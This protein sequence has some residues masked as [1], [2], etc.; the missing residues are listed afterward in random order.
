MAN[1]ES[2]Q[3]IVKA[4]QTARRNLSDLEQKLQAEIDEI[5]FDAFREGRDLTPDE[6]ARR[7]QA[8][9][10]QSEV[11]EAFVEIAFVTVSR[12]DHSEEVAALSAR[13][14]RINR[15]LAGDLDR[16]KKIASFASTVAKVADTVA[17]VAA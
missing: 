6:A 16:L 15:G 7:G 3:D 9:A 10:S 1:G 8:R 11:R 4:A 17:K 14:E 13:M 12:V 2:V 5:D